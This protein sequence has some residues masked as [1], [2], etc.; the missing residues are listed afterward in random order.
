[1]DLAA[2]SITIWADALFTAIVLLHFRNARWRSQLMQGGARM[3]G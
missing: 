2:S 1:M 3:L